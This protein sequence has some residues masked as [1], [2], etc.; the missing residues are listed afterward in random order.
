[1]YSTSLN[2]Q[3]NFSVARKL[4]GFAFGYRE[5]VKRRLRGDAEDSDFEKRDSMNS[6]GPSRHTLL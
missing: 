5:G 2:N 3:L 4:T 1:M 6:G